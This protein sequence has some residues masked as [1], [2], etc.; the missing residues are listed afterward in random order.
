MAALP[1]LL[2]MSDELTHECGIAA[3]RLKHPLEWYR[4]HHGDALWGLRRLYLL[5]EKQHNRGQDG[6][7]IASV[8]FD[9]PAGD[10]YLTRLRNAKRSPIERITCVSTADIRARARFRGRVTR[11]VRSAN[12]GATMAEGFVSD[13]WVD[14]GEGVAGSRGPFSAASGPIT[15]ASVR[16]TGK[17][18]I[19]APPS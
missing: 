4:E 16:S 2:P 5:M 8:R 10:E 19:A 13:D 12:T 17:T 15:R 6:A 11:Q 1:S 18:L 9:M 7:G 14:P 3:V